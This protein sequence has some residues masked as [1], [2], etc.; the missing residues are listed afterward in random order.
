M[1]Q[2]QP[3]RTRLTGLL[4]VTLFVL[5]IFTFLPA[6]GH[7]FVMTWDDNRYVVENPHVNTGLSQDNVI[8]AFT[9]SH[10]SNWHPLTWVSHMLDVEFYGLDAAGLRAAKRS[11]ERHG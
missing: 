3:T 5:T 7:D 10:H 8:W 2:I 11:I 4:A 9:S 1:I 6:V